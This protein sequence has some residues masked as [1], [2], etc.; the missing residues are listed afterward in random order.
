MSYKIIVARFNEDINWLNK[1]MDNCII[2]NKGNKLN[3]NNEIILENIGRESET[4]LN[5]I[6]TNYNNLPD[7]LV[8]TQAKISDHRQCGDDINYLI[9][10]KDEAILFNKSIPYNT[11][12]DITENRWANRDWNLLED[13]TYFLN[14]NYKNNI[15][16]I[17]IDWFKKYINKDYPVPIYIY[18]NGIFAVKKELI[19]KNA[20]DYYKN[21][22]LEVNHHINSTEG[23]FFERSWYYI[24]N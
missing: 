16:V 9:K 14:D 12:Y 11:Q 17:F 8:F 18:G 21:L 1:E 2:Y 3:I 22:I 10:L 24:F 23:H 4:Y 6:I 7:V 15:P 5:Y 20:I 19:L 13:G